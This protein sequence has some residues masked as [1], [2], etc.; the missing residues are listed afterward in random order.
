MN[1]MQPYMY[2]SLTSTIL[3]AF[4][5]TESSRTRKRKRGENKFRKIEWENTIITTQSRIRETYNP[6]SI[7]LLFVPPSRN[8]EPKTVCVKTVYMVE[9]ER[10]EK[11]RWKR[12]V[13]EHDPGLLLFYQACKIF[14]EA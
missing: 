10:A 1:I 14:V 2:Q 7:C 8:P 3:C 13:D 9:M 11:E 6:F 4:T 5:T 12:G